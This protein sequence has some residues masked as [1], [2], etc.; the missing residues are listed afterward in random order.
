MKLDRR[1]EPIC[2]LLTDVDGVLTDGAIV[3]DNQG[4]ESKA[5]HV[6][7]G[8][9]IKLWQKSGHQF[10]VITARSSHVVKVR[11]NELGVENVRQGTQNK[12]A[13]GLKLIDELGVSLNQTCYIGDDLS[14]LALLSQVGL[15]VTVADGVDEVK[16]CAHLVTKSAGGQ[17]AIRELVETMLKS[18]GRWEELI[19]RY[20]HQ[21][22]S[23]S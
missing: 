22:A 12:L 6:R 18:Q 20:R 7:D 5:F 17:G 4:I 21:P 15:A 1:I 3:Y 23:T 2:L 10:G 16:A 9:G 13:V 19:E 11:M 8:L 14:D